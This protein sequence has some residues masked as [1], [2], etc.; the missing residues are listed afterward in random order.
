[1][2]A[3]LAAES[4]RVRSSNP[5][6]A[7]RPLDCVEKRNLLFGNTSP[8]DLVGVAEAY[9]SEGRI[10]DALAFF[11]RAENEAGI[12][13]ILEGAVADG[14]TFLLEQVRLAGRE[15]PADAWKRTAENA[16][17]AGKI[18]FAIKAFRAA[19]D[20]AAADALEPGQPAEADG[21]AQPGTAPAASSD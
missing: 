10:S 9:L 4:R 5:S 17:A 2:A 15:V 3:S 7:R 13:K 8:S 11:V 18:M 14:D 20:D 1:M 16:K 12:A 21:P 6:M 19:G